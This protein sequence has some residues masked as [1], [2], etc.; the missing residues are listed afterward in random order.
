MT[1]TFQFL[2]VIITTIGISKTSLSIYLIV[3]MSSNNMSL[4]GTLVKS[5]SLSDLCLD[6][7]DGEMRPLT[8]ASKD[9][10]EERLSSNKVWKTKLISFIDDVEALCNASPNEVIRRRILNI[11]FRKNIPQLLF[12]S[13]LATLILFYVFTHTHRHY[14]SRYKYSK[15]YDESFGLFQHISNSHWETLKQNYHL[16]SPHKF[17]SVGTFIDDPN[18]WFQYNWNKNFV[19]PQEERVGI[20]P[21]NGGGELG[22]GPKWVCNSR[23]IVRVV[24]E[25]MMSSYSFD[26]AKE[27]IGEV[28]NTY[29][30]KES[31]NKKFQRR[32]VNNG[33]L[34]YSIG[35]NAQHLGFEMGIQKILTQEAEDTI[36]GYQ[37]GTPFC[38]IHVFDPDGYHEK[39]VISDGINYHNWGIKSSIEDSV[40]DENQ[41][42]VEFKT[43]Q[44][45]V[46]EL[47]H[48]GH[49]IDIMKVDCKMCEWSIY[50]DW[51][52]YDGGDNG[53]DSSNDSSPYE[54]LAMIQQLLVEVHGTPEQSVNAFFERL[55]EENYVIFHKD[56]N[57]E[58]FSGTS[59]DYAFLKLTPTFFSGQS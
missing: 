2:V 11:C 53:K 57:T 17:G 52:D 5:K 32:R 41:G 20:S 47:N 3:V 8:N 7:F 15:A 23:D 38:E 26:W 21:T 49:V 35:V 45:T 56:A 9:S 12:Y 48:E 19:C 13:I 27:K 51:F 37:Q 10:E 6:H 29:N 28:R 43:F 16:S 4:R 33:C 55:T 1:K 39:L 36:E 40:Q 58:Q 42:D 22:D 54:G 31:G 25:R 34:I 46:K 18:V 14:H 44:Q 24:N 59:Q 50:Q 30:G